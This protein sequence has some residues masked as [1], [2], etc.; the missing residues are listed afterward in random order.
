MSSS[1]DGLLTG[2][3]SANATPTDIANA[4][5]A[6]RPIRTHLI[7]YFGKTNLIEFKP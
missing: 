6:P 7:E 1:E 4:A 5:T 2:T 3:A